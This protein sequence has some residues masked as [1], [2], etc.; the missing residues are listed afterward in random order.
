MQ[1]LLDHYPVKTSYPVQWGDMDAAQHVNNLIY[2]RWGESAR[3][4][5]FEQM[6]MDVSFSRESVGPILGWQDCKYIFPITYPDTAWIGVKAIEIKKDRFFLECR[7]VSEKHQRVAA[8]MQ[9]S[10]IAYDYGQL[11]KAALPE[12]WLAAIDKIEKQKS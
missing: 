1:E 9:Q 12:E 6:G 2:M 5:Y 8:I 11:K 4:H 7:V 3:L 10:I